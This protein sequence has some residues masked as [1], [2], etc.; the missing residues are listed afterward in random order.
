MVEKSKGVNTPYSTSLTHCMPIL[1]FFGLFMSPVD[2]RGHCRAVTR[3]VRVEN[4]YVNKCILWSVPETSCTMSS[5]APSSILADRVAMISPL[6]GWRVQWWHYGRPQWTMKQ[7]CHGFPC[8][9][10]LESHP[11][12]RSLHGQ[13]RIGH[14]SYMSEGCYPASS[15]SSSRLHP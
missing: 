13:L 12:G 3:C 10:S 2:R 9:K 14:H 4:P 11:C 5:W 15:H 1:S 7:W 6:S 8:G